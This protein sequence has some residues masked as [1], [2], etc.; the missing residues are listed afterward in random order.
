LPKDEVLSQLRFL[1]PDDPG[2]C[3]VDKQKR[4]NPT[5]IRM[6]WQVFNTD[7]KDPV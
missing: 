5:S 1:F 3:K 7:K 2:L 4:Q 6:K